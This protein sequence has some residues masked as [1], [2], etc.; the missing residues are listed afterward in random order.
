MQKYSLAM[1]E[2][3]VPGTL[4]FREILEAAKVSGFD[5]VELSID[6]SD[7]RLARLDWSDSKK[8]E[9]SHLCQDEGIGITTMCLSGHRKYPFG[10]HERLIRGKSMQIMK[11]AL[12]FSAAVGIGLIQLAGYDVYY[13]EHDESTQHWFEDNLARAANLADEYYIRLGFETMETPFMDT[14]EK[15]MKYVHMIGSPNLGVYPDIGN[16][17]NASV[18]YG[19]DTIQDLKTGTGHIFAM[20]LKETIP[21]LYRNMSFGTTGHTRYHDCIE[22]AAH[23]GVSE[24]TGEFWYQDGRDWEAE[25]KQSAVFLRN[26]LDKVYASD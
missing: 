26:E 20:H 18:L 14:V 3:A 22:F 13:E 2:K 11:K 24:Y 12:D 21:G 19:H 15:A 16:L 8:R 5:R 9:L 4:C 25:T 10:S 7:Y 6:E 1:Y 17:E 23:E